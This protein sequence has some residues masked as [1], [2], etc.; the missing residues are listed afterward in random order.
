[1]RQHNRICAVCGSSFTE[2]GI[3]RGVVVRAAGGSGDGRTGARVQELRVG[4][5]R[6]ASQASATDMGARQQGVQQPA[7]A[8][9]V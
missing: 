8:A 4:D 6:G 3:V 1:M 9:M 7:C 2:R 5:G